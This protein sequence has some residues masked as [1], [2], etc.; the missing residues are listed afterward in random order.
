[1][2]STVTRAVIILT[3]PKGGWRW[4]LDKPLAGVP[5]LQ[6][7]V[8]A[9]GRAGI[10]RILILSEDLDAHR[11]MNLQKN[12]ADDPRSKAEV[13]IQD[14][15]QEGDTKEFLQLNQAND[16]V[17]LLLAPGN[18]VTTTR[19][20]KQFL[21]RDTAS[22]SKP[23]L[24]DDE[25]HLPALV[26]STELPQIM[27]GPVKFSTPDSTIFK[28]SD[29]K[30]ENFFRL[31]EDHHNFRGLESELIHQ[32]GHNY[33]QLLDVYFNVHFSLPISSL[34]IRL[35]VT[36][37]QVTLFGLV[38][39]AAAGWLFSR[40]DYMSGLG[41]G[42][43][44]AFTAIWDCCDGDVAR[45]KF[46]E[47]DFGETLDTACDNIINIFI[48]LGLAFGAAKVHGWGYALL[49]FALLA[50]GGLSIFALIYFPEGGKGDFFKGARIFDV[51]Q[52]LASRNF[53][54]V[55]LGFSVFG[56]LDWFL[57]LAGFGSLIFALILF[58]EKL[59]IQNS[60]SGKPV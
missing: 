11:R 54:Y 6:R 56:R 37:N 32:H 53:I 1:M 47:S 5:A 24:S 13:M 57:W 27:E 20:L 7:L 31:V 26:A 23:G 34:L 55:I 33:S 17:P 40:G 8:F 39:G 50:L 22:E 29:S 45:M 12:L 18:L 49:P 58:F 60:R 48:F 38:I 41:G 35:P 3:P 9:M 4:L 16:P 44:L 46:M 42:I 25:F 36:P 15:F 19:T 10:E 59:R 2:P 43:L 21:E 51:I 14:R 52:L 30:G 28:E